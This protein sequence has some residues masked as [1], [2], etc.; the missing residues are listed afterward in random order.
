MS[1]YTLQMTEEIERRLA[2]LRTS[3]RVSVRERLQAIV[4]S[5]AGVPSVPQQGPPLRFYVF[6]GCR[7]FYQINP[8]TRTVQVLEIRT[9][10]G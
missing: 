9:E 6:E 2:K 1:S 4:D 5:A 3:L 8:G 7:V 10:S